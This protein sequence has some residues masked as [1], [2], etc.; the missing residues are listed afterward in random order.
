MDE[1]GKQPFE[2]QFSSPSLKKRISRLRSTQYP[3]TLIQ[4]IFLKRRPKRLARQTDNES[5]LSPPR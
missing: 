4:S 5:L 2:R 3:F 1:P